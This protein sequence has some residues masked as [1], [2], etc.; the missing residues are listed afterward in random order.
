VLIL[1]AIDLRGGQCVRL[2][3][4]DYAQETV[5]DGDPPAVARRWVQQGANW[6]HIVDLDGARA[7][8][9]MNGDSIRSIAV[10]SGVPCQLGGG[11]RTEDD[12][13]RALAWGV[14]RV[15]I[16]TGALNS[17]AWF[18]SVCERWPGR[19]VL[20]IDA[21]DGQGWRAGPCAAVCRLAFG[22]NCVYGHQARWHAARSKCGGHVRH[23]R[24]GERA[25]DRLG[26]GDRFG[27]YS[28]PGRAWAGGVHCGQG[29]LRRKIGFETSFGNCGLRIADSKP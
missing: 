9:P 11:M 23:G 12:I 28:P 27:R 16:G 18:Q 4:G 7:G 5:F 8:R 10:A 19:V 14:Q 20:G 22:C 1:P 13:V 24:R 15:I 29:S 2:R 3:Q 17:P 26:R 25:G 21:K 6:L